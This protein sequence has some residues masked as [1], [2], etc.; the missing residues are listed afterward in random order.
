MGCLLVLA[1]PASA[2]A[3]EFWRGVGPEQRWMEIR[4]PSNLPTARMPNLPP[5]LSIAPSQPPTQQRDLSL[6]DA[7]RTAL[8]NS[9]VIRVLSGFSASSTG[10]TVYD[11]AITNTQIDQARARFDPQ[12]R[13]DN[14][15]FREDPAGVIVHRNDPLD[16]NETPRESRFSGSPDHTYRMGM[17]LSKTARSGGQADLTVNVTPSRNATSHLP[18][19]PAALN[20]NTRSSVEFGL[21]QPLLQGAGARVNLA[22]VMIA[23]IGTEQSLYRMKDNVQQLVRSVIDGYWGLVFAR[24]EVWARQQQVVQGEHALDLA[25]RR[26]K[27]EMGNAGDM[28][29]ARAS[30]A[31]FRAALISAKANVLQREAALANVLG[32]PPAD[33]VRIVPITPPLAEQLDI[34]WDGLLRT[35]EEFRPDLIELKLAVEADEQRLA[36]ARNRTLPEVNARASYRLYGLSGRQPDGTVI[37]SDPGQFT[38]WTL[39]VGAVVPLGE[40]E[41]RAALRREELTLTRDRA[42]LQQGLHN[43]TH[44]LATSYRNLAQFHAEYLAYQEARRASRFNLDLQLKRWEVGLGA[45]LDFLQASSNWGNNVSAEA[46]ALV[47]YNSELANLQALTGTILETHGVRFIEERYRSVGPWGRMFDDRCYPRDRRPGPNADRYENTA[48]PAENAFDL[49]DP[50]QNRR[51]GPAAQSPAQSPPNAGPM[52]PGRIRIEVPEHLPVPPPSR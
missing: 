1:I 24:T 10:Q 36:E 6:D 27:N 3:Q 52:A 41:S 15:F 26:F 30:L 7:I 37:A 39:G 29:Q 40:R 21:T 18:T 13:V 16:P 34:N 31:S 49:S 28:A 19:N 38:G 46:R 43:A 50:L 2:Y 4:H 47:N 22:P 11:P 45:F 12:F 48:E 44:Q 32:L 20:P 42:N 35:A 9:E 23:R 14:D 33:L 51:A 17:G 5:P 25:E 8:A